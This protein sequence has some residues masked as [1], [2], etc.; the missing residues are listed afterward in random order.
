MDVVTNTDM[1]DVNK[2][3]HNTFA[4]ELLEESLDEDE[5]RVYGYVLQLRV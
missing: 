4:E 2:V 3:I 5:F 1:M